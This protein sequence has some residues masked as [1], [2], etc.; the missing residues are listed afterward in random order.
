MTSV[1][2]ENR[3]R[4]KAQPIRYCSKLYARV[5]PAQAY[6]GVMPMPGEKRFQPVRKKPELGLKTRWVRGTFITSGVIGVRHISRRKVCALT[7]LIR[8]DT[9]LSHVCKIRNTSI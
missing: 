4:L 3:L 2:T 1:F 7:G 5:E 6:K 8:G 9:H